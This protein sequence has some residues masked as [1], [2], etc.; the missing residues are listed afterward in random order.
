M[1]AQSV[2]NIYLYCGAALATLLFT[3][4]ANAAE[5]CTNTTYVGVY[6]KYPYQDFGLLGSDKPVVQGGHTVTCG[7]WTGDLWISTGKKDKFGGSNEI[8]ATGKRDDDITLPIIGQ[9]HTQL[10]ASYFAFD[11]EPNGLSTTK[12]DGYQLK[13]DVG[14]P[15]P[16]GPVTLTPF[17]EISTIG[18]IHTS[19]GAG[20][21]T[22]R[23][24]LR[25]SGPVTSKM[26]YDLEGSK[27]VNEVN[28]HK[29]ARFQGSVSYDLGHGW[30]GNVGMKKTRGYINSTS[31]GGG[32]SY[33]W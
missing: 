33:T 20:L 14:R 27:Y 12:D 31:F 28:N 23:L 1:R 4:S 10:S 21:N 5:P 7:K 25:L 26:S 22:G 18:F 24:G 3:S 13:L 8:D 9:V 29:V 32:L 6:E 19:Y 17:G 15:I 2:L 16:I 30:N 11:F